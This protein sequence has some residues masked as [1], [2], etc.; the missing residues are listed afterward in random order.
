MYLDYE[1]YSNGRNKVSAVN[2]ANS[3]DSLS[4]DINCFQEMFSSA[5]NEK[6]NVI[7]RLSNKYKYS[8]LMLPPPAGKEEFT[9]SIGLSIYSK[10]P[11]I[12]TEKVIWKPNNNG[13]LRADIVINTDTVRVLNVQ[14]KSMGI[15]VKKVLDASESER[16]EETKNLLILLKNGFQVRSTQVNKIEEMIKESPYPVLVCGDFNE[17]PY[18]Y[19]Y[20][21]VSK[22]LANSFETSGKGFGFTYN[23]IL[24]FLR[25]DNQFFD[26][27]VLKNMSFQTFNK[28]P[29]SDHFPIKGVYEVK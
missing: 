12:D 5:K 3:I 7:K 24:G 27:K 25:I 1:A 4:A 28:I 18:G 23:K 21:R 15:R 16:V 11:I 10:Y 2:I 19:A 22:L 13:I 14:L 6:L 29:W 17:L 9:G 20:G 26:E 8:V